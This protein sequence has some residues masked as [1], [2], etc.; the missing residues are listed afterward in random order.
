MER[1]RQRKNVDTATRTR[2]DEIHDAE[3]E[4]PLIN[5]VHGSRNATSRVDQGIPRAQEATF[6]VETAATSSQAV[7]IGTQSSYFDKLYR[8]NAPNFEDG[9]DPDVAL[10]WIV[11]METKFMALRFPEDVK[12]QVVIPFLE[13][14]LDQYFPRA[15]R[16]KRQNDFYNLR[17]TGN[18]TVLQYANKFTS[19]EHFCP[20]VFEDEEEKMDQFEQGER[21]IGKKPRWMMGSN[22]AVGTRQQGNFQNAN[23][24]RGPVNANGGKLKQCETCQKFRRG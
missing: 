23:K 5:L 17:Q 21:S 15:L 1:E 11:Q 3:M 16:K 7:D 4:V 9:P 6:N 13:M 20:K 12:V 2:D 18:M 22:Q 14:F 10:N 24:R 19:L 8:A